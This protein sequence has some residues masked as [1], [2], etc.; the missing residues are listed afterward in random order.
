MDFHGNEATFEKMWVHNFDLHIWHKTFFH[1]HFYQFLIM[2]TRIKRIFKLNVLKKGCFYKNEACIRYVISTT[3]TQSHLFRHYQKYL[4]HYWKLYILIPPRFVHD[5]NGC[6]VT[7]NRIRKVKREFTEEF[8]GTISGSGSLSA[9]D[10]DPVL[11][12]SNEDE[13]WSWLRTAEGEKTRPTPFYT[14]LPFLKATARQ[15]RGDTRKKDEGEG[16]KHKP[17]FCWLV[18]R[19]HPFSSSFR[20]DSDERR[21]L[22]TL[23]REWAA[24]NVLTFRKLIKT[25][26]T[27]YS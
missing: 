5:S 6:R 9:F 14:F 21:Q 24:P 15:K 12:P 1:W 13:T 3:M 11:T 16:A 26:L 27:K 17:T 7:D 18:A 4:V 22:K 23:Q 10:E 2:S 25:V 19:F 8:E 20:F